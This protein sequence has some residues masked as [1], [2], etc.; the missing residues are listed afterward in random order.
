[1]KKVKEALFFVI[2]LIGITT[3]TF[4]LFCL[5]R[6]LGGAVF[7]GRLY[8]FEL[9]LQDT[10]FW[11]ALGN[12]YVKPLLVALGAILVVTVLRFFVRSKTWKRFLVCQFVN[13]LLGSASAFGYFLIMLRGSIGMFASAYS[14]V[15]ST[16]ST[17][18]SLLQSVT[19]FDVIT[20]LQ[21][22]VFAAFLFWAAQS[23]WRGIRRKSG[24]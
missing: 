11:P 5:R 2:P 1:M 24:H 10:T 4:I 20:A 21:V 23:V 16:Q 17:L 12:T 3:L 13:I 8:Y 9:L 14:A 6:Q 18:L 19:V 15:E 7:G 22:G